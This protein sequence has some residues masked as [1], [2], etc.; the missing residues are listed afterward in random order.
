MQVRH[1]TFDLEHAVPHWGDNVEACTVINGGAIIPPP[2]ERY[3]I[4]VMRQAK[5]LLDPVADAYLFE[6]DRASMTDDEIAA[7]VEG[8]MA[9]WL[10]LGEIGGEGLARIRDPHYDPA[11]VPPPKRYEQILAAYS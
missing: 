3:L 4:K 8:E 2:I 5:Q 6:V 11:D 7:S 1:P 9:A 10:G